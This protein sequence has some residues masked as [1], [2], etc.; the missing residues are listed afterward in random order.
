MARWQMRNEQLE[1]RSLAGGLERRD[2]L[3][4]PFLARLSRP[5]D[6]WDLASEPTG[7]LTHDEVESETTNLGQEC[8][9]ENRERK[10]AHF[11][12]G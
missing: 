10:E 7:E 1:R 9:R 4:R 6:H 5:G 11:G 12:T 2:L 3:A 8:S